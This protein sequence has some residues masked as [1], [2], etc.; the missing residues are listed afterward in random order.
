MPDQASLTH[1]VQ[2]TEG[3]YVVYR[4]PVDGDAAQVWGELF[5]DVDHHPEPVSIPFVARVMAIIAGSY[6]FRE[7]QYELLC[8]GMVS[9]TLAVAG[10]E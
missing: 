9:W 4:L 8:L 10:T 7:P 5:S 1:Y 6:E 2:V 3:D